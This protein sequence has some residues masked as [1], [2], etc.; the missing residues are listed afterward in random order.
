VIVAVRLGVSAS[1]R[2]C[3]TTSVIDS[4]TDGTTVA[5]GAIVSVTETVCVIEGVIETVCACDRLW[6]SDWLCDKLNDKLFAVLRDWLSD[7]CL[8]TSW[9]KY[10]DIETLSDKETALLIDCWVDVLIEIDCDLLA[11]K[12][13]D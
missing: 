12:D 4:V 7:V 9:L 13:T 1:V 3:V 8:E 11:S 5:V 6:L 10:V 2:L